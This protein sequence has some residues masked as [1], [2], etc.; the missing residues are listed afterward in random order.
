MQA[1]GGS[2]ARML[3]WLV[4]AALL[5]YCAMM[6]LRFPPA[7]LGVDLAVWHNDWANLKCQL[8]AV[9]AACAGLTK[10]PFAYMAISGVLQVMSP[11]STSTLAA[12]SGE[13][14]ALAGMALGL[15]VLNA[16][17]LI[18]PIAF[19]RYVDKGSWHWQSLTYVMVISASALLPFYVASGGLEL[20]SGILLGIGIASALRIFC[21]GDR[22][23]PLLVVLFFTVLLAPLY[24]DTNLP[25]LGFMLM[26][27]LL[28][29]WRSTRSSLA[30]Y[31]FGARWPIVTATVAGLLS[32]AVILAYNYQRYSSFLP[33]AYL[34]EAEYSRQA[35]PMVLQNLLAVM[36]SPN[37]GALV[38]WAFPLGVLFFCGWLLHA[39]VTALAW[40]LCVGIFVLSVL[41]CASWWSPFG[42]DGWGNRLLVPGMLAVI[43]VLVSSLHKASPSV[44]AP[45]Q[46]WAAGRVVA[47]IGVLAVCLCSAAYVFVSY[48]GQRAAHLHDSLWGAERCQEMHAKIMSMDV[49]SFMTARLYEEC[50]ADRFLRVPALYVLPARAVAVPPLMAPGDVLEIARERPNGLLTEGWSDIEPWGVWSSGHK[51]R[52]TVVPSAAIESVELSLSPLT[53]PAHPA[54]RVRV[55][56]GGKRV[57]EVTLTQAAKLD[58]PIPDGAEYDGDKALELVLELP[59]AAQPSRLGINQ[60]ER[61]LAVGLIA[62]QLR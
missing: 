16:L 29:G 6:L 1:L 60:D 18:L 61:V 3:A 25:V 44:A 20:Q 36:F 31:L 40:R 22:R 4:L 43:I 52:L 8:F 28:A 45:A 27:V 14:H 48:S 15:S 17:F 19:F 55:F 32:L 11:L 42:W 26:L 35:L 51:A 24:K 7:F 23:L 56:S 37:G 39:R 5:L 10:F 53:T 21:A 46:H 54:Q 59:D 12:L 58:I 47:S 62:L 2:K 30:A 41:I 50:H 57:Y 9:D 49:L 38:F 33:L 13:A 34:H